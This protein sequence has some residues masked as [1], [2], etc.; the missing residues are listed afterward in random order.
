MPHTSQPTLQISRILHAGYLFRAENVQIAFDPIFENPFS[1]NCHA[2]P[3]V[4]FDA[5]AIQNQHFDA[6]FISH[7]HDDHCSFA[8]LNLLDRL[9]PIYLYCVHEELFTLLREFGFQKVYSL[10]RG[11][12]VGV[13]P[14][15]ITPH[16]ALNEDVDSIFEI[17]VFDLKILNMVDS[18]MKSQAEKLLLQK[19]PWDVVLWPFQMMREVE[20]LIPTRADRK[21]STWPEEC[22]TQLRGLSPRFVVPSSCQLIHE[23]WSWYRKAFFSFSYLDFSNMIRA[24]LP[25]TQVI[26]MDPGTSFFLNKGSLLPAP[27]LNWILPKGSQDVDYQYRTDHPVQSVSEIAQKFPKLDEDQVKRV[28]HFCENEIKKRYFEIGPPSDPF[29]QKERIWKLSCFD[30]RGHPIVFYYKLCDEHLE[31]TDFK[32]ADWTTEICMHKLFCA[33]EDGETLTSLY[34][35]INT[36]TFAESVE[37]DLQTVDPMEDPLIRTL[38]NGQ[39]ASFQKAQLKKLYE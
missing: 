14:F 34:L 37:E 35:Q 22:A 30:H 12:S 19:A 33:L 18:W 16:R 9:T 36:E 10:A 23:E 6:V 32:D 31:K 17:N 11:K 29:F 28:F 20:V 5:V 7:H 1:V 26:R 21:P 3:D 25:R 13:G 4:E 39:F 27:E 2:F 24:L 8:S 38:Y 15:T